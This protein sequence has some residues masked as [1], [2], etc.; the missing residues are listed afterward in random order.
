MW[1]AL[2][3]M[4]YTDRITDKFYDVWGSFDAEAG[5]ANVFPSLIRLCTVAPSEGDM[6]EVR[7]AQ[8][9]TCKTNLSFATFRT[10]GLMYKRYTAAARLRAL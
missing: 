5:G 9:G 10:A 7:W 6:R 4:D 8:P 1:G 3:S 2:R